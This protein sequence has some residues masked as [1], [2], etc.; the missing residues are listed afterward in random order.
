MEKNPALEA[1]LHSIGAA[2]AHVRSEY[3]HD[4]AGTMATVGPMPHYAVTANPGEVAVISGRDGVAAL[5]EGAHDYAIPNSSRF[6]AQ[7]SGDWFMFV[8]NMPTREWVAD[9][10]FRTAHTATLLIIDADGVKGEYV[11]ERPAAE[12][13]AAPAPG[14]LPLGKLRSVQRHEEFIAAVRDG[15]AEGLGSVLAPDCSWAER[16]YLNDAE[17]GAILN[18]SGSAA[19]A[20]HFAQ[21][22]DRFQPEQVSVLNRLASEW[23]VFAEELWTVRP[24]GGERRQYRKAVIYAINPAGRIQAAVGYGTDLQAPAPSAEG[25]LGQAF[26]PETDRRNGRTLSPQP[27]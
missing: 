16:D 25:S 13:E 14:P 12:A 4:L 3:V 11:W 2:E 7:I 21:W 9:G 8:E 26:W 23:Y 18:L 1:V 24:K 27:L 20:E 10:S 17:G 5:Y 22:R 6:L 15:D 19:T